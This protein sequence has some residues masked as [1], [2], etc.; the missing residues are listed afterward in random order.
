VVAE[1]CHRFFPGVYALGEQAELRPRKPEP[2]MVQKALADLGAD[3]CVYV[4]DTQI[5]VETAR[6]VD[7][8]CLCVLWGF[9]DREQLEAVGAENFCQTPADLVSAVEKLMK[10]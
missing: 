1:L 7:A 9:R 8:P 4:G 6:N 5:D 3:G 10:G 2:A